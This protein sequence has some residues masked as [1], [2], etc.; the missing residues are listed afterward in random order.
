MSSK[1]PKLVSF[2]RWCLAVF[3]QSSFC[4]TTTTTTT[5]LKVEQ[6]EP[7]EHLLAYLNLLSRQFSE[8]VVRAV[9]KLF[10]GR[11]GVR[12][13]RGRTFRGRQRGRGVGGSVG[14]SSLDHLAAASQFSLQFAGRH[15]D[16][17]TRPRTGR[18]DNS[19]PQLHR[20]RMI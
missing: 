3:A 9:G 5:K 1:K 8:L 7:A 12:Q 20:Y 18:P 2:R 15:R 14:L 16:L 11:V 4:Y 10:G 13:R 6:S 19:R 17:R